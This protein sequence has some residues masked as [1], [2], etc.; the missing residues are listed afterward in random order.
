[1]SQYPLSQQSHLRITRLPAYM[2]ATE[3]RRKLHLIDNGELARGYDLAVSVDRGVRARSLL[4]N[5][6]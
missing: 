5:P 1:M 2:L 6:L 4:E 3:F